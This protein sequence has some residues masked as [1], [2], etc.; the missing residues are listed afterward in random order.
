[1]QIS[2]NVLN[3]KCLIT[4]PWIIFLSIIFW[5]HMLFCRFVGY[6]TNRIEAQEISLMIKKHRLVLSWLLRH[7]SFLLGIGFWVLDLNVDKIDIFQLRVVLFHMSSFS[8]T[9]FFI[10]F[11]WNCIILTFV[12]SLI[13]RLFFIMLLVSFFI[14][15]FTWWR[16]FDKPCV[17][18]ENL[19][20]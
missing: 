4:Y 15:I 18:F 8:N 10:I 6:W 14:A 7:L 16:H 9:Y 12:S 19:N 20:N 17:L 5:M 11:V 2:I 13:L 1:M 3:I